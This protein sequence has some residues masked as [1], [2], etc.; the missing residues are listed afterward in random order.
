MNTPDGYT[1][2]ARGDELFVLPDPMRSASADGQAAIH[3]RNEAT[4]TGQCPACGAR[5]GVQSLN[6]AE[7]R[8]LAREHR[9]EVVQNPMWHEPD[10]PANDEN[11]IALLRA[12]RQ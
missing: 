1:I 4:L 7:R 12:E 6:R 2:I 3:A 5:G 8:R 11:L 10:C 9:G